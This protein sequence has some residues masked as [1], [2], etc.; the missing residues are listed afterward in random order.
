MFYLYCNGNGNGMLGIDTLHQTNK[1][2]QRR[3]ISDRA[4]RSRGRLQY[5]GIAGW[6]DNYMTSASAVGGRKG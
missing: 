6:D 5:D 1:E 4:E 2:Q 3:Q